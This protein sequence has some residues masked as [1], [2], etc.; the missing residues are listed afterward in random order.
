LF[1]YLYRETRGVWTR[2]LLYHGLSTLVTDPQSTFVDLAPLLVP[3][4][5]AK[6]PGGM[7]WW[8]S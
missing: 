3:L 7:S 4:N 5:P 2:E 1:E 6:R 8:G